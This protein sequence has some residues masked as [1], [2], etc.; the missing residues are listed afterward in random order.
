[1]EPHLYELYL[2]SL[3]LPTAHPETPIL[4]KLLLFAKQ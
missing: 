1:M 3:W 4:R 2:H